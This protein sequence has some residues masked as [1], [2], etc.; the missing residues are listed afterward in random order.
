MSVSIVLTKSSE[1]YLK[2]S[3]S[4]E[5]IIDFYNL[6][7]LDNKERLG[8]L[9]V[10]I[11]PIIEN[12]SIVEDI[13]KWRFEVYQDIYPEWTFEDDP[14]LEERSRK[15]LSRIAKE[16][17][18]FKTVSAGDNGTAITGDYGISLVVSR[19]TAITEKYGKAISEYYG[20]SKSGKKGIAK[21]GDYGLS[22]SGPY[23]TAIS[24]FYG[25][26]LVNEGG[27]AITGEHGRAIAECLGKA[28]AGPNGTVDIGWWDGNRTRRIIGYVGENGIEA[29]VLYMV[30]D[31]KLVRML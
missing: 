3:N 12:F 23:G 31:G 1:Y 18:F 24:G 4:H 20:I 15:A 28:M 17:D 27:T 21:S 10:V 9:K 22:I 26:S 13:S 7:S 6:N 25:K 2:H 5:D 29:N 14:S 30:E 8:I 11:I 16:Q 19:G